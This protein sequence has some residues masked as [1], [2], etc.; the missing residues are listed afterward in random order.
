MRVSRPAGVSPEHVQE[1]S[2][3]FDT[4]SHHRSVR[5]VLSESAAW[6][7]A[8]H[9]SSG[10]EIPRADDGSQDGDAVH[11]SRDPTTT[12]LD[13]ETWR[14]PSRLSN[15]PTLR[16]KAY[17]TNEVAHNREEES[18]LR[19]LDIIR[20]QGGR[21][22][23]DDRAEEQPPQLA[24]VRRG[25]TGTLM[26]SDGWSDPRNGRTEMWSASRDFAIHSGNFREVAKSSDV[27]VSSHNGALHARLRNDAKSRETDLPF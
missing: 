22:L 7:R 6:P 18:R 2:G 25:S 14:T 11:V 15:A 19:L 17:L 4:R 21:V 9:L 23:E 3:K 20:C 27:V 24:P 10:H 13:Q 8:S 26:D 1:L 16:P 12:V 5:R